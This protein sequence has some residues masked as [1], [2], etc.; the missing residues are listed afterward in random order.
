MRVT[1][2]P[3]ASVAGNQS[4]VAAIAP[5]SHPEPVLLAPRAK[6]IERGQNGDAGDQRD[7]PAHHPPEE[8]HNVAQLVAALSIIQISIWW[9]KTSTSVASESGTSAIGTSSSARSRRPQ[10]LQSSVRQPVG[11]AKAL[12]QRQHHAQPGKD[13]Q[14]WPP[15]RSP[16]RSGMRRLST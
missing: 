14:S 13:A 10:K 8:Q 11:A 3:K 12:H 2:Q 16:G 7:R 6:V 1:Y 5:G 4:S 15:T 9:P